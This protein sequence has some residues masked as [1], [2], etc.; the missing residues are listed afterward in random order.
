M[1]AGIAAAVLVANTAA[2]AES[3]QATN[4]ASGK[5][6]ADASV[7]EPAADDVAV[8]LTSGESPAD[9]GAGDESDQSDEVIAAEAEE[10]DVAKLDI[11]ENVVRSLIRPAVF[12]QELVRAAQGRLGCSTSGTPKRGV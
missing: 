1:T 5:P 9:A 7:V 11:L 10:L 6:V 12:V 4:D 3:G 8:V 2:V